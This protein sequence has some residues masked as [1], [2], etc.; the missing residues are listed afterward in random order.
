M[1]K[2]TLKYKRLLPEESVALIKDKTTLKKNWRHRY[3]FKTGS[4]SAGKQDFKDYRFSKF[5]NI[6]EFVE[7]I[8]NLSEKKRYKLNH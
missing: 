1:T 3:L 6:L 4:G 5:N 8:E 2:L 7:Y